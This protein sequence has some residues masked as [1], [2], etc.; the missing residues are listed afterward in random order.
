M[1]VIEFVQGVQ[2]SYDSLTKDASTLYFIKDSRRIYKGEELIASDNV[3]IVEELPIIKDAVSK[4]IYVII[5][6][7][8]IQ[9]S[10]LSPD[11]SKFIDIF[12]SSD[13]TVEGKTIDAAL[14]TIKN[15]SV[16]NFSSESISTVIPDKDAS[17]TKLATEKAVSD[18]IKQSGSIVDVSYDTTV[19]GKYA[20]WTF[21]SIDGTTK[22]IDT[23]KEVFLQSA[24]Y[25]NTTK[26][27]SLTMNNNNTIDIDMSTLVLTSV[28]T[29]DVEVPTSKDITVELGTNGAVGGYKTGDVIA[30]GTTI[31][32]I[33]TK[34]LAKQVPPT[35]A[36]PTVV[37]ANNNG[38]ASGSYEIG[39][40]IT[41]KLKAT[42]TK[43]DAGNLTEIS[44]KKGSTVVGTGTTSPYTV[45]DTNFVLSANTSYNATVT[46]TAGAV[47]NDN[48]GSPYPTGR[49]NAG[50]KTSSN[51]TFTAYRQG[52]FYGVLD[53]SSSEKPL[54][55]D[56][57][58]SCNKKNGAYSSGNLPTIK[59]SS[60]SNPKRVF[61]AC[62]STN[63]GITKVIMP[64]AMNA[65]CTASFVKQPNTITVEGANGY[66]GI[67]YNVWVYE[68]AS[69]TSDQTFTV[70]LG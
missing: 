9:L 8:D 34:L 1:N 55:S 38:T 27:L 59:A 36:Q 3:R 39:T 26:T 19:E 50:S 28:S 12:N 58:R 10:I 41:P 53:S 49:I 44:I 30:A 63:K 29:E 57:I 52:Y 14:N 69:I 64:S 25:D 51:Y 32:Q 13:T 42:F 16:S 68:P 70:T 40:T 15:L 2:S 24:S 45:E 67:T 33:I 37:I 21:T 61:V 54:T 22:T 31:Q 11:G 6:G 46:Y 43:N 47:K 20:K 4:T 48:L 62:P 65:D 66:A 23:L 18:A 7:D 5:K 56:I 60:V 35:Y 17:D